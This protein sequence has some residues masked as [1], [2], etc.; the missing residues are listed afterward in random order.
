[1]SNYVNNDYFDINLHSKSLNESKHKKNN[2]EDFDDSK[3]DSSYK[4]KMRSKSR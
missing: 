4:L 3:H 1:M 2:S